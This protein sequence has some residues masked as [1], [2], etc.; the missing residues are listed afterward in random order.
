MKCIATAAAL[1][2]AV[3]LSSTQPAPAQT[4]PLRNPQID[5]QYVEPKDA[6]FR[7]IYDRVRQ[8]QALEELRAFLAPLKLPKRLLI[9]T[10]Q[11]GGATAVQYQP[12]GPV[13]ICYE[14]IDQLE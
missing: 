8:R 13:T 3:M 7:P 4:S 5:I 14:F 9:K 12:G 6:G 2:L 1:A 11:C 10:D